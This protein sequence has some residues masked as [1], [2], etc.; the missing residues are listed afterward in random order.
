VAVVT[1]T[2]LPVEE[3]RAQLLEV[4][5]RLFSTHPWDDVAMD[6]IAAEVG[7]SKGLLYHYFPSKRDLYVAVVRQASEQ[8]A[9]RIAPDP[10]LPPRARLRASLE[11]Y[12]E[13]AEQ[14]SSAYQVALRGGVGSDDTVWRIV[15][16][17]RAMVVDRLLEGLGVDR[18]D[19][20]LRLALRGWVGMV[21]AVSLDWIE[22]RT[23][24]RERL[25][26]LMTT[27]LDAVVKAAGRADP[28][29]RAQ[30][31]A[32]PRLTG[33]GAAGG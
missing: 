19:P 5:L 2:R 28:Q 12:L 17:T 22:R 6:D 32:R 24:G 31:A 10:S 3:R 18:P 8:F 9:V 7:V 16:D 4:G 27:S 15:E 21:E 30:L 23:I 20:T 1:W 29:A 14:H 33:A 26:D 11:T 25:L 13:Y